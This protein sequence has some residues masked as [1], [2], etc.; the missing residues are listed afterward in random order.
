[1]NRIP[2]NLSVRSTIKLHRQLTTEREVDKGQA[3]PATHIPNCG[4]VTIQDRKLEEV[5]AGGWE[6]EFYRQSHDGFLS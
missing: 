2:S 5:R 6:N 3:R 1:M 4:Q